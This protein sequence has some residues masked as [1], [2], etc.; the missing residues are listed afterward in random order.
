MELTMRSGERADF[1]RIIEF[2][3]KAGLGTAGV[4]EE[5]A[6][7]FL[8]AEKDGAIRGSLGIEQYG[9]FGLL[10]SLAITPGVNE[11]ELLSMFEQMLLLAKNKGIASLYL[12]TNKREAIPFFEMAGF[13]MI[14]RS[15]LPPDF[16]N[17]PHVLNILNVDNSV[18]L[19][20]SI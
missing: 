12:A 10:R 9:T 7:L 14:V 8:L 2:L 3:E 18:F 17:S 1:A 5:T 19:K 6:N 13:T 16:F 4:T 11:Q 15:E 20:F